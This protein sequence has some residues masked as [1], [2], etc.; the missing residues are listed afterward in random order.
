MINAT[1]PP[2]DVDF[3]LGLRSF[4]TSTEGMASSKKLTKREKLAEKFN[5]RKGAH[6]TLPNWILAF[7]KRVQVD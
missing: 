3:G 7:E 6:D 4:S 5:A 1:V 2:E